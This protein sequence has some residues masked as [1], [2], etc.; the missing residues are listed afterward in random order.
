RGA[1]TDVPFPLPYHSW[2]AGLDGRLMSRP[3]EKSFADVERATV[4]LRE[5]PLVEK[6]GMIWVSPTPGTPIDPDAMLAGA[7]S[8]FAAYGLDKWHLYETRTLRQRS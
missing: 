2:T 8:D 6:Y 5:L 1:G 3:D 7:E 4:G